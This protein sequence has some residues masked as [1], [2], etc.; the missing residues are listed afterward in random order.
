MLKDKI[1]NEQSQL[2]LTFKS[3]DCNHEPETY[4]VEEKPKK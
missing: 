4:R 1:E 3:R 2:V